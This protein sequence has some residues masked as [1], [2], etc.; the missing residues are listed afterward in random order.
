MLLFDVESA[1]G[2]FWHDATMEE[3]YD[4]YIGNRHSGSGTQRHEIHNT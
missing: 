2:L 1:Y 4:E 3:H